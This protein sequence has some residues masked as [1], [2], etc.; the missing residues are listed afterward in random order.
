MDS[1]IWLGNEYLEKK[2][3]ARLQGDKGGQGYNNSGGSTRDERE[4]DKKKV[5]TYPT[6]A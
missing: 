3:N 6:C 4:T 1:N 5:M 2:L